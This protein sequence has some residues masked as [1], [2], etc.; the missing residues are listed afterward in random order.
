MSNYKRAIE[1]IIR[2]KEAI[3]SID[4]NSKIPKK[5]VGE[6]GE[7]YV[8]NK[9]KKLGL[10]FSHK[11]G[12]AGYD[13]LIENNGKKVE[14]RTSLLKNEGLYPEDIKFFGWRVKNRNQKKDDKFDILIGVALDETFR[15]PKFYIFTHQE[16]FS[17]EDVDIGRFKNVQKKIHLFETPRAY[18]EAVSSNLNLVTEYERY[19]N[20]HQTEFRDKWEK[21][22][23][24][25]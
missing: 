9:L 16:A 15:K 24:A 22:I 23:G 6:V 12:Q 3:E 2:F 7:F 1:E 21:I 11:G 17:V 13:I 18:K 10:K 8:L 5:L 20:E 25:E 14:V 19:I 4:P